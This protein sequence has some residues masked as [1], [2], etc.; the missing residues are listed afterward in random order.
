[1]RGEK[2]AS[3]RASAVNQC[4]FGDRRTGSREPAAT[5]GD[6]AQDYSVCPEGDLVDQ[7]CP[8]VALQPAEAGDHGALQANS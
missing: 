6:E 2:Y 7:H 4:D 5:A 8:K 1:M 3:V